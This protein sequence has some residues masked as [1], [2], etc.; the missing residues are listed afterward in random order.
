MLTN[1]S[2]FLPGGIGM[3]QRTLWALSA[4]L[5]AAACGGSNFTSPGDAGSG[6]DGTA[7]S[8]SGSG[9]SGGG[10]GS[11]SGSSS[12]GS[13][14]S[15][16][17]SGSGSGSSSGSSSGGGSGS[18][19]GGSSSGANDAGSDGPVLITCDA[20]TKACG[21]QCVDTG[22][23][24]QNCGGCGDVCN[25]QCVAGVC[26]LIVTDGGTPPTV[27]DNAC[28]TV[29][30]T[31]VYWGSGQQNGSVWKVPIGGGAPTQ[32][33]GGQAAPH[34]IASDGTTLFYGNQGASS[35]VGTLMAIPVNGNGA[36]ITIA[37]A[38]CTPQDVVVDAN[39]VYWTNSGDGSVW[40]SD[41]AGL[42]PAALVT[43]NGPA[44]AYL[45]VDATNV[46]FTSSTSAVGVV[47][48]VPIAGGA[49]TAMTAVGT[50]TGPGHIAVDSVNAY[51]G[52][53]NTSAEILSIG[54]SAAGGTPAPVLSML[55]AINGIKTDGVHVWYAEA[56]GTTPYTANSGQIHRVTVGGA[57][58][59][60]L[61]MGQNGP[62]CIA[63]DATSVYW[64]NTGGATIAKTGK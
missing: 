4:S 29:D 60:T 37:S 34:G 6:S 59:V 41:K 44:S 47:N 18:S 15:S 17:G 39:N 23:D 38:Q 55:P 31:S 26:A 28:L 45:A 64:I 1:G 24:P 43:G 27:G 3:R 11:S 10:S 2:G 5:L 16:S 20:G 63:V 52:A 51:F 13:S 50:V 57:N 7:S 56:S 9:S 12:G 62:N 33:I 58:D 19:S 25:T 54:L 22:T 36:A 8:G 49:V 30:A 42:H 21:G 40:K 32:V 61:A 35:C 48:R 14:G 46:Y 53:K